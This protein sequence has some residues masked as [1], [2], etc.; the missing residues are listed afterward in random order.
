MDACGRM[1]PRLT[2][3]VDHTYCYTPAVEYIHD[4]VAKGILG[5][6]LYVDSTASISAWFSPDADVFWDLAPH[7]LAIL[8]YILPGGLVPERCLHGRRS[9]RR[10][11]K[12]ASVRHDAASQWWRR[13][14]NVNWMSPT[15]IRRMVIGGSHRHWYGMTSIPSS[16]SRSTTAASTLPQVVTSAT[17]TSA[18]PPQS[19]TGSATSLFPLCLRRKHC[20]DGDR[21][22]RRDSGA[23]ATADGRKS[24]AESACGAGG[25]LGE[26]GRPRQTREPRTTGMLLIGVSRERPGTARRFWSR[27]V[28]GPSD[29]RSSINCSTRESAECGSWTT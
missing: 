8:D 26:S 27:A 14:V 20:L 10:R 21:V 29:R 2:L 15:K 23:T 19:P 6:V 18:A 7:D 17:P 25:D 1:R 3:M 9:A 13:T 22:R 12:R 24:W 5:H 16:E 11:A 4:T 28:Q